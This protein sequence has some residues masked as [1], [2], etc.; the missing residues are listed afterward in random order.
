MDVTEP[1]TSWKT[2]WILNVEKEFTMFLFCLRGTKCGPLDKD[3]NLQEKVGIL[4]EIA[5]AE[6]LLEF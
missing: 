2:S 5:R 1:N 3:G 6:L 4:Y